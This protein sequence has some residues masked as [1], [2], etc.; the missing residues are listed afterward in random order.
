MDD[1]TNFTTDE[2]FNSDS[3]CIEENII[4][5]NDQNGK[6]IEAN[7]T[8]NNDQ[9]EKTVEESKQVTVVENFGELPISFPEIPKEIDENKAKRKRNIIKNAAGQTS[10]GKTL[11]GVRAV[12]AALGTDDTGTRIVIS[13]MNDEDKVTENN[14]T[15]V[16]SPA[17]IKVINEKIEQPRDALKVAEYKDSLQCLE[18]VRDNSNSVEKRAIQEVKNRKGQKRLKNQVKSTATHCNLSGEPL[19]DDAEMDHITRQA[20]DPSK[21]L[22]EDNVRMVNKEIH[23][24]RHNSENA[25]SKEWMDRNK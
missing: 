15:Y 21:S 9:K 12:K 8:S 7:Q 25:E 5:D 1:N 4:S 20:D 13:D 24:E 22:S 6:T 23:K 11:L 2:T 18:A 17:L 10:D 19:E 3:N 16:N 14:K